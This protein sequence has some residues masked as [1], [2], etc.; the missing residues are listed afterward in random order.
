MIFSAKLIQCKI[1]K[2]LFISP[3]LDYE[4]NKKPILNIHINIYYASEL[5]KDIGTNVCSDCSHLV[6][7]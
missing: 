6:N 3:L 5:Y 1:S 7:P 2:I 4:T